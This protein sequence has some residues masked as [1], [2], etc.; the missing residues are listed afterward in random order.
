MIMKQY[1]PAEGRDD[2]DTRD[3]KNYKHEKLII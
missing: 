3:E 1:L 2:T